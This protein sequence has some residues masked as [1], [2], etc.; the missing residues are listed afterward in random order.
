MDTLFLEF[1]VEYKG[2]VSFFIFY[3]ILLISCE[4]SISFLF[5]QEMPVGVTSEMQLRRKFL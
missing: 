5:L 2:V 3:I 1:S 4:L